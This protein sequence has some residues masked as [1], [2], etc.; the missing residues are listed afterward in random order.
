MLVFPAIDMLGGKVVRLY[1]GD[2]AQ[3]EVYG[4]DPAHYA[5]SFEKAGARCLHVVDL[6]GAK[7]G[8][9]ANFALVQD[10]ARKTGLF[11]EFGGGV[12]DEETVERCLAAI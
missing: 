8:K 4:D 10:I 1:Q 11:I 3:S 2:Y 6:D 5:A 12:R 7:A 9:P